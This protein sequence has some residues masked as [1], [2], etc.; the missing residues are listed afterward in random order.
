MLRVANRVR[1]IVQQ[2]LTLAVLSIVGTCTAALTGVVPLWLTVLLHEGTTV[3]VGLNCMRLL[4]E[5]E[6]QGRVTALVALVACGAAVA[7]LPLQSWAVAAW[8]AVSR[9]LASFF[10]PFDTLWN[11]CKDMVGGS[12]FAA[13]HGGG[14][15]HHHGDGDGA[16]QVRLVSIEVGVDPVT[17]HSALVKKRAGVTHD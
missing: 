2:N 5:E 16:L 11:T 12:A 13:E 4:L 7:F 1:S 17:C 15:I 3:L 10:A 9:A 6:A 8:A 14:A